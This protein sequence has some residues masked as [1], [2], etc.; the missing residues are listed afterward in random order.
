MLDILADLII[1]LMRGDYH[2]EFEQ[3]PVNVNKLEHS[4]DDLSVVLVVYRSGAWYV[5]RWVEYSHERLLMLCWFK[6]AL[7]CAVVRISSNL[8]YE[9]IEEFTSKLLSRDNSLQLFYD[10]QV[11]L[12]SIMFEE[13]KTEQE[14]MA[15]LLSARPEHV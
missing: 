2:K 5:R 1:S 7:D 15:V 12:S 11:L 8:T 6:P 9:A 4:R 13:F 10:R 3:S 14:G